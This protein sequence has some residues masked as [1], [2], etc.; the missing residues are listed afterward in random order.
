VDEHGA[1]QDEPV[2]GLVAGEGDA[3]RVSDAGERVERAFDRLRVAKR[4]VARAEDREVAPRDT[5]RCL[6]VHAMA[7]LL[8]ARTVRLVSRGSLPSVVLRGEQARARHHREALASRELVL[9]LGEEEF[10]SLDELRRAHVVRDAP[11]HPVQELAGFLLRRPR[12]RGEL[13]CEGGE[14]GEG[15]VSAGPFS[16]TRWASATTARTNVIIFSEGTTR[17][18]RRDAPRRSRSADTAP[19]RT[20]RRKHPGLSPP[21]PWSTHT[22]R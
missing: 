4:R 22:A 6:D 17:R 5:E 8:H 20:P 14:G 15:G 18:A 16:K 7:V 12:L 3:R 10:A 2:Q 13:R 9:A 11:V 19:S 1:V 21:H